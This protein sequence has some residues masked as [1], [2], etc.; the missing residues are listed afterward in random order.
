MRERERVFIFVWVKSLF[1]K[2]YSIELYNFGYKFNLTICLTFFLLWWYSMLYVDIISKVKTNVKEIFESTIAKISI[3]RY[4]DML[5]ILNN[6]I[7]L[8]VMF[9]EYF[10]TNKTSKNF[11]ILLSP[12]VFSRFVLSNIFYQAAAIL[13]GTLKW[14][15]S[16]YII[17]I[18]EI[19]S[20]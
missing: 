9:K 4:N 1:Q 3:T 14:M 18:E 12:H 16:I 8:I 6:T 13:D 7:L 20:L 10:T 17:Y 19:R 5:W 2:I 11:K 15:Q